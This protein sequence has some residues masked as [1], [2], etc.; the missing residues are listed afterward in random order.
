MVPFLIGLAETAVT[1]GALFVFGALKWI[2]S[3]DDDDCL[4]EH[5]GKLCYC[6][7]ARPGAMIKQRSNTWS[8]LGFVLVGLLLLA[9]LPKVVSG[10]G[11]DPLEE[12][13][14][15]AVLYGC[16]VIFLG[17]GSMFF[18]A[19]M[20]KWAGWVDTFSMILFT[21]FLLVYDFTGIVNGGKTLFLI[22]YLVLVAGLGV[23]TWF[24]PK[25]PLPHFSMGALSFGAMA[26]LWA[27]LQFFA[28]LGIG[29]IDRDNGPALLLFIAGAI[30][31]GVAFLIQQRSGTGKPWCQPESVVQG[32][33]IWHLL[34]AATTVILFFYLRT[35]IGAR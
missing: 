6:E 30:V 34:T 17:P 21:A 20:K 24:V 33:A 23:L 13:T 28:I 18:H 29:G 11:R 25:S 31:F 7:N 3:S 22:V 10:A 5:P 12:R 32:H 1:I 8:N 19:S 16:I 15:Y 4:K 27:A 26:V 9:S 2:E 14:F 35:E